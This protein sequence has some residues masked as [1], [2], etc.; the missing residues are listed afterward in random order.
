M[1]R[2][3]RGE[4]GGTEDG[5]GLVVVEVV[6]RVVVGPTTTCHSSMIPDAYPIKSLH[7]GCCSGVFVVLLGTGIAL[8]VILLLLLV[9]LC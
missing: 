1:L 3:I 2:V 8:V 5:F 4:R 7:L 9:S 6:D